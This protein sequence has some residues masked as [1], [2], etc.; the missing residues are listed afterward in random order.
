ML[1]FNELN[2]QFQEFSKIQSTH[3]CIPSKMHAPHLLFGLLTNAWKISTVFDGVHN[4]TH[5]ILSM[6]AYIFTHAHTHLY[7]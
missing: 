5:V 7:L 1:V 4:S 2:E 3:T 6:C